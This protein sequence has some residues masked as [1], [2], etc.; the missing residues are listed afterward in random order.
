MVVEPTR[1]LVAVDVNTGSDASPAAALKANLA[2]ARAL[3][4]ADA[5]LRSGGWHDG[6]PLGT[7]LEGKRLLEAEG[8]EVTQVNAPSATC[9][10][11]LPM[12]ADAGATHAEPGHA[13]T[14]TTPLHALD[15]EQPETPA[16]VYVSEVSHSLPGGRPVI[17]GGGFYARAR[18]RSALLD[19]LA[20]GGGTRFGVEAALAENIDYYRTLSAAEAPENTA[21][22]G[23]T[24]ILAFRTQVFVTRSRV[25]VVSGLRGNSPELAGIFD[26]LGKEIE[27]WA[28]S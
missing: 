15:M 24:A 4:R 27:A 3:P 23:A 21:R 20:E 1:A 28:E 8:F 25:A 26:S 6:V 10:A 22:V 14:G 9:A 18:V 19:P 17:Y 13:L 16:M 11:T 5:A 7:V 2:A 12:L